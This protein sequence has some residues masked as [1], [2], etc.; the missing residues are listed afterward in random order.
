LTKRFLDLTPG[1]FPAYSLLSAF[2]QAAPMNLDLQ[3]DGRVLA[4][5]FH[6]LDN[7]RAAN[8]RPKNYSWASLYDQVIGLRKH[9]FS[10]GAV[11][12][13][14]QA[15]RTAIPRWLNVVRALSSEG[16]GRI[17]YD[18]T[19]RRLLDSDVP[20]RSFVE[21]ETTTLP[22]F[23]TQQ[24]RNDLGPFWPLLPEGALSHDPTAYLR[25]HQARSQ[26]PVILHDRAAAATTGAARMAEPGPQR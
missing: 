26:A 13:R 25:A 14:F 5:P 18:S 7:N 22:A 10:W 15:N 11:A 17:R 20:F 3:R 1:V 12:R 19:V 4:T 16:A 2:G 21:G 24:V 6:F 8:V 9:S 23:Y